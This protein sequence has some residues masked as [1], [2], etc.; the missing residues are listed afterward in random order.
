MWNVLT[1][2]FLQYTINIISTLEKL[3]NESR[4]LVNELSS[5][6][7]IQLPWISGKTTLMDDIND[8]TLHFALG[9]TTK[10]ANFA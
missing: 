2:D 3:V 4:L 8:V 10:L 1:Q 6:G 5:F 9:F 7:K